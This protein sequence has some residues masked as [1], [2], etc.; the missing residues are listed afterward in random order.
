[1]AD[2]S[3]ERS[4]LLRDRPF[5]A[6]EARDAGWSK[7]QL[8][9]AVVAGWLRHPVRGVYVPAALPDDLTLRCAAIALVRPPDAFLCDHI[10]AWLHAGDR[11]LAPGDHLTVPEIS[12]FRPSDGGRMRRPEVRSGERQIE[13]ADLMEIGGMVV[14]TP[15]RT[16]WDLGRLSRNND[17]RLHAMDTM[18]SLGSFTREQLVT[19][20]PRFK[21]QR[22]VVGLRV[23]APLADGGAESFGESALRL[24]WH[25]AGLPRPVTQHPVAGPAGSTYYLDLALPELRFGGEY[26]GE[27]FHSSDEQVRKDAERRGW[28]W[29]DGWTVKDFRKQHVFGQR[30]TAERL[31]RAAY[32]DLLDA[33]RRRRYF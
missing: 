12:C 17:V 18:L 29:R 11:A 10:A 31:L 20:V 15:L 26:D 30:Q 2:E 32:E 3:I 14:T 8:H 5:L 19:G 1:M 6:E 16:A 25:Q 13:P 22:G 21:G 23:L 28:M 24:R 7:K 33:H 27:E 4:A 9:E